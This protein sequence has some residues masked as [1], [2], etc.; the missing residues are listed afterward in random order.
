[1]TTVSDTPSSG[2]TYNHHYENS[3]G[4]IYDRN[5]FIIQANGVCSAKPFMAVIITAAYSSF[6]FVTVSYFHPSLMF[7]TK[8][9]KLYLKAPLGRLQP[10]SQMLEVIDC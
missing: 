5:I 3:R 1:L 6:E 10:F 9:R 8:A 2:I 4:A 7:A